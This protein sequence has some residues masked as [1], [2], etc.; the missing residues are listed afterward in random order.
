M[1]NVVPTFSYHEPRQRNPFARPIIAGTGLALRGKLIEGFENGVR[2]RV[3]I[4]TWGYRR[5]SLRGLAAGSSNGE[6]GLAGM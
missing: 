1:H 5:H 3:W 2:D 4:W 6:G